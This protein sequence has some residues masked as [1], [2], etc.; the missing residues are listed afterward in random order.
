MNKKDFIKELEKHTRVLNQNGFTTY[1][2][3]GGLYPYIAVYDRIKPCGVFLYTRGLDLPVM[4]KQIVRIQKTGLYN[5]AFVRK[6]S[7]QLFSLR[8]VSSD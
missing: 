4:Y 3:N 6:N 5:L 7:K 2:F 1:H 8:V